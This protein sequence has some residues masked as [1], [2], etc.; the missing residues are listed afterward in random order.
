MAG[1]DIM[2]TK[3]KMSDAICI[4]F[5]KIKSRWKYVAYLMDYMHL[6]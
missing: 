4:V 1:V 6:L 2:N 3:P 5:P